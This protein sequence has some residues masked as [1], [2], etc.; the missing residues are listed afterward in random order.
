[1]SDT[2]TK[3]TLQFSA[4]DEDA[5]RAYEFLKLLGRKKSA[6]IT[7]LVV[8]YLDSDEAKSYLLRSLLAEKQK[9]KDKKRAK[10][11]TPKKEKVVEAPKKK[12]IVYE[13]IE[14][15]S[16]VVT[17]EEKRTMRMAGLAMFNQ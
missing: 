14:Q 10:S 6:F 11:T 9:N 5:L 16:P 2:S 12:T 7:D 3:M 13:D 4:N 15:E 17:N 8:N 1:M